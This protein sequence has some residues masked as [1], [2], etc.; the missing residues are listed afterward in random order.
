M[1][2]KNLLKR[3]FHYK[4]SDCTIISEKESGINV[5]ITSIKQNLTI[6]EKYI[7]EHPR[8]LFSLEPVPISEK[9]EVV[10]L[11]AES[12]TKAGVGP[13]AAVAGVLADLAIKSMIN[14]GCK[15]AVVENGGE[16]AAMSN[17][18]IDI[19]LIAGDEPLSKEMGFRLKEFP[20]GVATSSGRFSHAF[21]FGDADA[22]T[23]F[24]VDAGLAD[25]TA[26][27]VANLIKGDEIKKVIRKGIDRA[28]SIEGVKGIFIL[29]REVV[30][31]AG[32]VPEVIKI[33]PPT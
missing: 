24:A 13:M 15:V 28:L 23:I 6:L 1:T 22:V 16:I 19:A 20:I 9:P 4:K 2:N 10:R 33:K 7:K 31:K 30:G 18:S 29:Y 21:S 25:A 14:A 11:M 5:A 26:T 32:Q 3:S 8:F 17:Q 12:S 27:A